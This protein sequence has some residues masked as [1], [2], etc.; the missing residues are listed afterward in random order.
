MDVVTGSWIALIHSMIAL[1]H[2][3]IALIHFMIASITTYRCDQYVEQAPYHVTGLAQ[4]NELA[5]ES[6]SDARD[7]RTSLASTSLIVP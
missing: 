4:H 7:Q 3:M 6:A 5:Q 1:I 2:S